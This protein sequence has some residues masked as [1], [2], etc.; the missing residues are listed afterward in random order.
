MAPQTRDL[1]YSSSKRDSGLAFD[2]SGGGEASMLEL[3]ATFYCTDEVSNKSLKNK[4][5]NIIL[6]LESGAKEPEL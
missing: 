2:N 6:Q 5:L 4:V 1:C 3:N